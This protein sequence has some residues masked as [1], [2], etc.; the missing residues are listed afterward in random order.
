MYGEGA[1]IDRMCQK[2]FANFHAG[3]FLLDNALGLGRPVE[4]DSD[5]VNTLTEN[6][7]LYTTWKITNT[8]KISKSIK[9]SVK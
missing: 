4:I 1:V 5:Q 2:G 6:N 7:Q 9:L 8:L 3:D